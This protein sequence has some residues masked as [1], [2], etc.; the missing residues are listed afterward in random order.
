MVLELTRTELLKDRIY[1][2]PM[3]TIMADDT[4]LWQRQVSHWGVQ[5]PDNT[6]PMAAFSMSFT[7]DATAATASMSWV[8]QPTHQYYGTNTASMPSNG[9]VDSLAVHDTTTM[10]ATTFA[11]AYN[12]S[13]TYNRV[14]F[15]SRSWPADPLNPTPSTIPPTSQQINSQSS[16]DSERYIRAEEDWPIQAYQLFSEPAMFDSPKPDDHE[17]HSPT[18]TESS[19]EESKPT[20]LSTD[21]D[22]LMRAI[23]CKTGARPHQQVEESRGRDEQVKGKRPRKRYLCDVPGCGKSFCQKTH[24]DI[25]TVSSA[26]VNVTRLAACGDPVLTKASPS[27]ASIP[28]ASP[29][30]AAPQTAA[31][32]SVNLG[33]P[34]PPPPPSPDH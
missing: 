18:A 34:S 9:L 32:A 14:S 10:P 5:F 27:S 29:S 25:H 33:T 21:I 22:T 17:Q 12:P 4:L 15:G 3:T 24:L 16:L 7:P 13:N 1:W 2:L 20:V 6:R 26:F 28:A 23:Q 11:Q 8:Q 31:N 19:A 30:S